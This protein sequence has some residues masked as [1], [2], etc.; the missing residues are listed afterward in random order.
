[1]KNNHSDPTL[2]CNAAFVTIQDLDVMHQSGIHCNTTMVGK[3]FTS[4]TFGMP[5]HAQ[6]APEL[7]AWLYKMKYNGYMTQHIREA[8][9]ISQCP[10]QEGQGSRIG[11]TIQQLTG[12]WVNVFS[13]ALAGIIAKFINDWNAKTPQI[14]QSEESL[15][16]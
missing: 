2:Y 15:Q 10:A 4:N 7:S 1:M 3:I 13:F 9:P 6:I 8:Q 16:V 12:I 14:I 11:L 5:I